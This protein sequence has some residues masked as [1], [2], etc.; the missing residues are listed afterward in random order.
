MPCEEAVVVAQENGLDATCVTGS[1]PASTPEQVGTVQSVDQ[2]GT[3]EP[4]TL[5]TLTTFADVVSIDA[6]TTAPTLSDNAPEA[7]APNTLNWTNYTCPSGVPSLS[8]Y[9]VTITNATFS[10]G[11]TVR[12]FTERSAPITINP[13][14]GGQNV[15]ATYRVFC[16]NDRAS[17]AS[18]Q[19]TVPIVAPSGIADVGGADDEG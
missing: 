6:P 14:T 11:S 12:N 7:G 8:A 4:G 9:E 15:T 1:T 17:G 2:T 5:L 10:D 16:G 13:D 19:M 18:P 3:V